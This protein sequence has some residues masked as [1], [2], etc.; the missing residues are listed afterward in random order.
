MNQH[1]ND[2]SGNEA[3]RPQDAIPIEEA[4]Q[5]PAERADHD[6]LENLAELAGT[7]PA[8]ADRAPKP[9]ERPTRRKSPRAGK[10]SAQRPAE[11]DRRATQRDLEAQGFSEDEARRLIDI[12]S[13]LA[14]SA[15]AREAEATARRLRFTRWL[16]EHGRLNEWSASGVPVLAARGAA[17]AA[18]RFIPRE[19]RPRSAYSRLRP[20]AC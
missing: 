12:S 6:R 15:E 10:S 14:E 20:D 13:R 11:L 16:V 7:P 1:T 3:S 18:P 19:S 17:S 8:S 5:A 2:P 9:T 4:K